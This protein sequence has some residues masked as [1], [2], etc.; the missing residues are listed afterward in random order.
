MLSYY[1]KSQSGL[2]QT[3]CDSLHA[4]SILSK[5][6]AT[7]SPWILE[8]IKNILREKEE[9]HHLSGKIGKYVFIL[10][11]SEEFGELHHFYSREEN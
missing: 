9:P 8:S 1:L 2:P 4:E 5:L 7:D 6:L 3:A 10:I 11:D